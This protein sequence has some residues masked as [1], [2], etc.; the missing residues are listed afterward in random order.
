MDDLT[1]GILVGCMTPVATPSTSRGDSEHHDGKQGQGADHA[2]G[3]FHTPGRSFQILAMGAP[4]PSCSGKPI[5]TG[6]H[7]RV[8]LNPELV[9]LQDEDYPC[10]VLGEEASS[11]K[12]GPPI[13]MAAARLKR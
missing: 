1:P 5:M 6:V 11:R 2:G 13:R 4:S 7:N 10:P 12:W 3:L 9:A 8:L